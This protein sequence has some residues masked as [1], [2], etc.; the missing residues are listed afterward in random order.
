MLTVHRNWGP[1]WEYAG[2]LGEADVLAGGRPVLSAFSPRPDVRGWY[3]CVYDAGIRRSSTVPYIEY[4]SYRVVTEPRATYDGD[5]EVACVVFPDELTGLLTHLL[6]APA[7]IAE[8]LVDYLLEWRD[9]PP[10]C[11]AWLGESVAG[12]HV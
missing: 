1:G 6:T 12:R 9:F 4:N 5:A 11:R 7:P 2:V 8:P 3:L 10:G